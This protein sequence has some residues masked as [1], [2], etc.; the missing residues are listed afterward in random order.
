MSLIGD[1]PKKSEE[2]SFFIEAPNLI[3]KQRWMECF[4]ALIEEKQRQEKANSS[5]KKI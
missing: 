5:P 4:K 1:F 3:E 2:R